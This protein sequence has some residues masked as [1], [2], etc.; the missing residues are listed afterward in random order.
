Q[1][2]TRGIAEDDKGNIYI[3]Y[4]N[5]IHVLEPESNNLRPLFPSNDF[6]NYPFGLTCFKG[7]LYTGNGRRIDLKTLDVDTLFGHPSKDLGHV[8][9]D[10]DSLLWI[11]YMNWLYQYDPEKRILREFQDSKGK[12]DSL[13][14]NI[15]YLYQ[16]K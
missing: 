15:S 8:L 3:S 2:S 4:Y 10:K 13:A 12:W 1:C 6:F 9:A 5:S 14:G 11:G 7:A 16:G